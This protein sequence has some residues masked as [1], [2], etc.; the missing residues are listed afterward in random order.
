[1]DP[2]RSRT[3]EGIVVTL[4]FAFLVPL[5]TGMLLLRARAGATGRTPR[6]FTPVTVGLFCIVAIPS[7]LQFVFPGILSAL[8]RD[9]HLIL[10]HGEIWR[11]LTSLTVQDGGALG[12]IFNLFFLAW[13]AIL[14]SNLLDD[15][16]T[17]ILFFAGGLVGE[18][19]GLRWQH[20]G[21]GNSVGDLGLA[22]GVLA[23]AFM[24]G[25]PLHRLLAVLGIALGIV[26]LVER[27]IHG[28]ALL[29]G[30][31]AG[32]GLL[33]TSSSPDEVIGAHDVEQQ[34]A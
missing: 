2:P 16:T 21:G 12:T 28:A 20:I 9:T 24:H 6:P 25:R 10:H 26:L 8:R 27:N 30:V 34:R 13:F 22:G 4:I 19:V 15:R 7:L 17:L 14:A 29:A 33:R 5:V 3:L 23:L 11:L 1:V 32:F 31:V 18:L